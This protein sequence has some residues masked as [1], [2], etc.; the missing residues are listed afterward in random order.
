MVIK[1]ITLAE[2]NLTSTYSYIQCKLLTSLTTYA[3][4]NSYYRNLHYKLSH[5][6]KLHTV[7]SR[8]ETLN[9]TEEPL[10]IRKVAFAYEKEIG[11]LFI[12]VNLWHS[13]CCCCCCFSPKSEVPECCFL[14]KFLSFFSFSIW[15]VLFN[16][17]VDY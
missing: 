1:R 9:V 10:F 14:V 3:H 12:Q 16:N 2:N 17:D 4:K 7:Q 5:S 15:Q 11:I 6:C 13:W 8:S